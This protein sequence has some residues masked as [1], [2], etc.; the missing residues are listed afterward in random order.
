MEAVANDAWGAE[1]VVGLGFGDAA[2]LLGRERAKVRVKAQG[3]EL[4]CR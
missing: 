2:A 3:G 4:A 1:D